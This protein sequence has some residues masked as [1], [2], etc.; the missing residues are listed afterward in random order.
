MRKKEEIKVTQFHKL[1][2]I[3][4]YKNLVHRNPRER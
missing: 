2:N 3:V 4:K 1:S